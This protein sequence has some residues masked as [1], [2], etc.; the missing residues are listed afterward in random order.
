MLT[1]VFSRDKR[2]ED[3]K[4]TVQISYDLVKNIF[5]SYAHG[6]RYLIKMKIHTLHIF[7]VTASEYDN[8]Q[9]KKG[10][11]S[12]LDEFVED[13]VCAVCKNSCSLH[14]SFYFTP[15]EDSLKVSGYLLCLLCSVF[16]SELLNSLVLIVK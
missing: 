15:M 6:E 8:L 13:K 10:H 12:K 11:P 14:Q 16:F 5:S 1:Y 2:I 7:M 4:M 9:S 3:L